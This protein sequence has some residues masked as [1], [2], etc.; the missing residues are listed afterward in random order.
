M[1]ARGLKTLGAHPNSI[2]R[3]GAGDLLS[4]VLGQARIALQKPPP[5][6]LTSPA[7]DLRCTLEACRTRSTR[8]CLCGCR[9]GAEAKVVEEGLHSETDLFVVVVDAGPGGGPASPSG[10]EL[11]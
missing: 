11:R 8:S 5:G 4:A 1:E 7:V 6:R 2:D 3:L 10:V 9:L